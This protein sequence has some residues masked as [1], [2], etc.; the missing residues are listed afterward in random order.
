VHEQGVLLFSTRSRPCKHVLT[1][2]GY[3]ARLARDHLLDTEESCVRCVSCVRYYQLSSSHSMTDSQKALEKV[4][5]S[6]AKLHDD[7]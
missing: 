4:I 2:S 5:G 6:S 7:L 1:S 3:L